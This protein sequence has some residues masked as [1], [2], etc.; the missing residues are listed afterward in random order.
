VVFQNSVVS[1]AERLSTNLTHTGGVEDA[2]HGP[3]RVIDIPTLPEPL[4]GFIL[5]PWGCGGFRTKVW[6]WST[7]ERLRG[8][9]LSKTR[10]SGFQG[11]DRSHRWFIGR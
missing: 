11:G 3:D 1:L 6:E 9:S 4:L 10:T 5:T 7:A 2:H 8:V